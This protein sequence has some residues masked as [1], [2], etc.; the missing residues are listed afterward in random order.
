MGC[1]S[2]TFS[3]IWT[4]CARGPREDLS[5]SHTP[6]LL[7]ICFTLPDDI[8]HYPR[9]PALRTAPK[10]IQMDEHGRCICG[11]M[12]DPNLPTQTLPCNIYL[13]WESF[14]SL[15]EVQECHRKCSGGRPRF[16]GPDC[17]R[18]GLFNYNNQTLISHEVLDDYTQAYTTSETPFVAWVTL[19][20]HR[21]MGFN[22]KKSFVSEDLF[23]KIWF[24]YVGL[25]D[26]GTN[27]LCPDCGPEPSTI[28]WDGVTLAF[29]KKHVLSSIKPP[30]VPGV[31]SIERTCGYIRNQTIIADRKLRGQLRKVVSGGP[32]VLS[33]LVTGANQSVN[34]S[35][36]DEEMI[37][38]GISRRT[39]AKLLAERIEAIPLVLEGLSLVSPW[40]KCLFE[41]S[42]SLPK[43][44]QGFNTPLPY[45]SFFK[46]VSSL[47]STYINYAYRE[48]FAK[49]ASEESIIQ[50]ISYPD[51]EA[52]HQFNISP[53][54]KTAENLKCIPCV[55]NIL[56]YEEFNGGKPTVGTNVYPEE[57]LG[58]LRFL[59]IKAYDVMKQL[60]QSFAPLPATQD[61]LSALDK[62]MWMQ[63]IQKTYDIF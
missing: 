4:V 42:Y 61:S 11:A 56:R 12:Y 20:N 23:R 58:V 45:I 24:L 39:Q 46:E 54:T 57:L 50:L 52:L 30:T 28:I 53:S 38:G 48:I 37:G 40:L 49:M 34:S 31:N 33:S 14:P 5:I 47:S 8:I 22:S 60:C 21:Y 41:R 27:V 16:I 9:Q 44:L 32:L 25:Q 15:I 2:L 43:L 35:D 10:Q 29:G 55:Y 1:E 51:F 36:E 63:V 6:I 17:A 18:I 62:K 3:L 59:A 19:T 26:F 13:L 7:P